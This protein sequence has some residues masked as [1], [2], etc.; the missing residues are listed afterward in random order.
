MKSLGF[1]LAWGYFAGFLFEKYDILHF[2][3]KLWKKNLKQK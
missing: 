3:F 1:S 2:Y